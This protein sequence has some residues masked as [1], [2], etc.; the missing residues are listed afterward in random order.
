MHWISASILTHPDSGSVHR[1]AICP[2]RSHRYHQPS[3]PSLLTP[4]PILPWPARGLGS[5]ARPWAA[6]AALWS[7]LA[8]PRPLDAEAAA[9]WLHRG[10][11]SSVPN[12]RT[13]IAGHSIAS[14]ALAP[15]PAVGPGWCAEPGAET[16][17]SA[18][19]YPLAAGSSRGICTRTRAAQHNRHQC[20]HIR[21]PPRARLFLRY[22]DVD[23]ERQ[24]GLG[25]NGRPDHAD[26]RHDRSL[27]AHDPL[28]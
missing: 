4:G 18:R 26:Q 1:T 27:L 13:H 9:N 24:I 20:Q 15:R 6:H 19:A 11:A 14:H 5:R 2:Q 10:P 17:R 28:G 21:L 22:L 8:E 12:A 3:Q 23:E 16:D 25:F 7:I